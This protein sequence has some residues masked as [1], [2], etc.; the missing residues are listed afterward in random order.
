MRQYLVLQ[1]LLLQNTELGPVGLLTGRRGSSGA[2]ATEGVK[3]V[4]M[5]ELTGRSHCGTLG[6]AVSQSLL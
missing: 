5:T 1:R 2:A 3:S 4:V 6:P